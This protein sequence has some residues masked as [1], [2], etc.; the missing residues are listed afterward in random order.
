MAIRALEYLKNKFLTGAKPAQE[1]YHDWMDSF[2][3]KDDVEGIN[4]AVIDERINNYDADLRSV[5]PGD[6][7]SLGDVLYVLSGFSTSDD[8]RTMI[9]EAS[10]EVTWSS[11]QSKPV[12]MFVKWEEYTIS[13]DSYLPS[14]PASPE[15]IKSTRIVRDIGGIP[16]S[17]KVVISDI[18]VTAVQVRWEGMTQTY[19]I[20]SIRGVVIG[21]DPRVTP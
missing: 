17:Q 18:L 16:I 5:T 10:G 19:S 7:S 15:A 8:I 6:L 12:N 3:H 2:V 20:K 9:E 21:V 13:T 11:I 14:T 1:D 4:A